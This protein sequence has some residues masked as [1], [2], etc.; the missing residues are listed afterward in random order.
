MGGLGVYPEGHGQDQTVGEQIAA[1]VGGYGLHLLVH[2]DDV[3]A[4]WLWKDG[5]LIDRYWSKP[6]Y[7]REENRA[8]EESLVGEV[9]KFGFVIDD[10]SQ[11]KLRQILSR[12]YSPPMEYERLQKVGRVLGIRR[13]AEAYEYLNE[14]E[15]STG[16][17]RQFIEVPADPEAMAADAAERKAKRKQRAAV[18]SAARVARKNLVAEGMLLATEERDGSFG[19]SLELIVDGFAAAWFSFYPR[20][21]QILLHRAPWNLS[22]P[23]RSLEV[24]EDAGAFVAASA[25]GKRLATKIDHAVHVWEATINDEWRHLGDIP[26][27]D[28]F[29]SVALSPDGSTIAYADEQ[30]VIG[31]EIASGRKT[32][33]GRR[34]KSKPSCF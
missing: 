32:F 8:E 9:K 31:I 22:T 28:Q 2:D 12:E 11:R 25:D 19:P 17:R 18:E 3:L 23:V 21:S 34:T 24:P 16:T 10:S 7:F 4:Y 27:T 5:K 20:P 13:L 1:R 30:E 33:F 26:L 15:R 14:E 29:A 6:G